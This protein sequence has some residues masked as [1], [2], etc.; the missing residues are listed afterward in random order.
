MALADLA[1]Y[2]PVQR[3][4]LCTDWRPDALHDWRVCGMGP[5]AS[6]HLAMM[7]MLGMLQALPPRRPGAALQ[8]A[9]DLHRS[10]EAS[11]LAYA[12][13]DLYLADPAFVS[14]PAGDWARLLAPAY[15]RQRASLIGPRAAQGEVA[16]G[17]PGATAQAWAPQA[18]QEEHGTSHI[19]IVDAQGRMVAM[20]TTIESGFGSGMLCDGGT[21]LPGG[22]LLNNELT[23]FSLRPT[24]AHGRPVANRV[25]S[26]KRP[27]SSMS[28]TLVFDRRTGQAVMSLGSPGG[29]AIIPFTLKV[30][31]GTLE[32]GL[33][34]QRAMDQI[35]RAHV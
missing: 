26:G 10:T 32:A 14:A 5:P 31:R 35:G 24:D 3:Q 22:F 28:P 30:L 15:L 27:R 4:P 9:E 13:R 23:D 25:E 16:A 33:T 18:A 19:S 29:A 2:R 11:R 17:Q 20:T 8:D 1:G 12:D 6:G 21:G 7:Q 34:P